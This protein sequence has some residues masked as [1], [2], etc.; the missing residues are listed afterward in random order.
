M[1]LADVTV[2][3]FRAFKT[4]S[5]AIPELGRLLVF[6]AN[7]SGKS[8]LASALDVIGGLPV[9]GMRHF[10][11]SEMLVRAEFVLSD[12]ER[13][14]CLREQVPDTVYDSGV[15]S[16]VQFFFREEEGQSFLQ[17]IRFWNPLES[18]YATIARMVSLA[19]GNFLLEAI[20]TNIPIHSWD[21]RG[22]LQGR[23]EGGIDA[24]SLLQGHIDQLKPL[25]E[26]FKNW[27]MGYFHF[28]ANRH[29][30]SRAIRMEEAG[31][32]DSNGTNLGPVLLGLQHNRPEVWQRLS[33]LIQELVPGVG[34]LILPAAGSMVDIAF[35][36]MNTGYRSNL[37]ELGSGVEQLLMT[38]VLGL[39]HDSSSIVV[40]EEPE[41][42]LHP[43]AQRALFSLLTTWGRDRV[44]VITT[45]STVLID[46]SST[47]TSEALLVR[48]GEDGR[49]AVHRIERDWIQ[50]AHELGSRLSD[51]LIAN[52]LL[53]VEG[54]SDVGVLETWFP[55][56][57]RDPGVAVI[58]ANG[59]DAA[60]NASAFEKWIQKADSLEPRRIVFL[61]DKDELTEEELE[62]FGSSD[63]VAVLEVR[64]LENYL[65]V[66][67]ALTNYFTSVKSL[68][69]DDG[70]VEKALRAAAD[71]LRQSIVLRT[72]CRE[73]VPIRLVDNRNRGALVKSQAGL[74]E[75]ITHV[76]GVIP[77][78]RSV[79]AKIKSR[80]ASANR[81]LN[82]RWED[83]W[84]K[85]APGADV[86]DL[87]FMQF[88]GRH[89]RKI[90]DG[91]AL[92]RLI[93]PPESLKILLSSV[94]D[95]TFSSVLES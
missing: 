91:L 16:R 78:R 37:E 40:L 43:A 48:K 93:E 52:R 3:N 9:P 59:G 51:I 5:F 65:M 72:V 68:E 54:V 60:R 4:A 94:I 24:Q 81:A 26:M 25:V 35:A 82:D 90:D 74:E 12:Q 47:A 23:I 29:S 86:L 18:R 7:N 57:F 14:A 28:S 66:P 63:P 17:E 11:S 13:N 45:H 27:R 36:D 64:E 75:L 70:V 56:L 73:L 77:L 95:D 44:F 20:P 49:S 19:K 39:T 89:Y 84:Q 22:D 21:A 80:W 53:V 33:T 87:V 88:L 62:R 10:G 32:L 83:D 85:L 79:A 69:I 34:L 50:I 8:A 61:R 42:G 38:L 46:S 15:F 41:T 2:E 67:S 92:S 6:G 30:E 58:D 76:K 31:R 71:S 55:V 1:F